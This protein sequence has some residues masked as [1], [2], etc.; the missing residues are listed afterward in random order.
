MRRPLFGP[1]VGVNGI[2]E[3]KMSVFT[4]SAGSG[5]APPRSTGKPGASLPFDAH[6]RFR[7]AIA[8]GALGGG[9]APLAG[10]AG[11]VPLEAPTEAARVSAR[12]GERAWGSIMGM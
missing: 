12:A 4:A 11:R 8:A 1:A 10:F 7:T 6:P 2:G 5:S 9:P 3:E